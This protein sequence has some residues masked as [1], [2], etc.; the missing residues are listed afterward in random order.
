MKRPA[1]SVIVPNYNHAAFLTRRIESVLNQTMDNFEVIIL[2][3]ASTDGSREVIKQFAAQDP[4]IRTVFNDHNSGSPFLQWKKGLELAIGQ[5]VWIAESDDE[6]SPVFLEKLLLKLKSNPGAG[7]AYCQ[8]LFIDRNGKVT[9][10][11]LEN[12]VELHPT[13]WRNDFCKDGKDLVK[14]FMPIMNI[15]PNA[16]AAVFEKDICRFIPWERVLKYK[17]AGDRYFWINLLLHTRLCFLAE[18]MNYFRMSGDTVRGRYYHSIIYLGEMLRIME[19][20]Q[21]QLGINRKTRIHAIGQWQRHYR[22]SLRKRKKAPYGFLLQSV[23]L[24]FRVFRLMLTR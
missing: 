9:G 21:Q 19:S 6:A 10:N 20:I 5:H 2:D 18:P 3:D 17:L 24:Y 11:H 1:V 22:M 8:S 7:I 12:M 16:S 14:Q 13:L 23:T 15:I 4:R